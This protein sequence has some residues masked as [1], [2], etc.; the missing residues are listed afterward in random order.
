MSESNDMHEPDPVQGA[1]DTV[2][3]RFCQVAIGGTAVV[4]AAT[5]GYPVIAFLRLPKSFGPQELMEVP[6]DALV[7]GYGHW[8]EHKGRQIVVIKLGDEIR[9]FDGTCP[10]LGCIVRWDSAAGGFRCPCHDAAF[11]DLGNPIAGPVNQPLRRVKFVIEDDVLKI[12]DTS[13][14]A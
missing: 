3:R 2:R 12:H 8:G 11:D 13:A 9:A 7:E 4:S 1:T 10:H 5:I 6:L 14:R